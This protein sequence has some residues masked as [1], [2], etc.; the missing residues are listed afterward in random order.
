MCNTRRL[1]VVVVGFLLFAVGRAT[2][3]P[4]GFTTESLESL[5]INADRVLVAKIVEV[6]DDPI[7]G[8]SK[9]PRITIEIEETLKYPLFEERHD[10]LGLFVEHPTTGFKEFEERSSRLLVA[11]RDDEPFSPRLIELAPGKTEVFLSDFTLLHEPEAVVEAAREIIRRA[12]TNV[13]QLHTFR[14]VIPQET[15]AETKNG[16]YLQLTVPV[17]EQLQERAIGF[18]DS[19]TYTKRSEAARILR[20]FKSDANID[21]LRTLLDDPGYGWM[22]DNKGNRSKYYGVRNAAYETLKA[23]GV[24]VERPVMVE[25]DSQQEE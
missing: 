7:P 4:L 14:L 8:G 9:R 20:Y 1:P 10:K 23:W 24:E 19:K 16:P 11:H 22:A 25:P 12:P 21:R 18:L 6:R 2:A 15:L 13:R 17:D 5:V 3:Q